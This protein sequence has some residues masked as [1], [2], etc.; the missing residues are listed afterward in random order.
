MDSYL[1]IFLGRDFLQE[2]GDSL[3][4]WNME[5]HALKVGDNIL[6]G[7]MEHQVTCSIIH[8]MEADS[9]HH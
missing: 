6:P 4:L 3:P 9:I 8:V 2:V 1:L 7:T 5:S